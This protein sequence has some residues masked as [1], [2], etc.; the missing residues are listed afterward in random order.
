MDKSAWPSATILIAST[1]VTDAKLVKNLLDDEFENV[2]YSADPDRASEDF[3]HRQPD[4]LLLAFESLEKTERYNLGLFRRSIKIHQKPHRTI[5]LCNRDEVLRAYELCRDEIFD[6][7]ILFWPTAYDARRL[8]MAVHHALRGLA[9]NKEGGATS[10]DFVTQVR[11]L[12]ELETILKQR[13][14]EG[15]EHIELAGRAIAQAEQNIAAS[16]SGFARRMTQGELSDMVEVRNAQHLEDAFNRLRQESIEA[17]LHAVAETFHPLKRWADDFRRASAPHLDSIRTLNTLAECVQPV[18]M[19]VDDDEFQHKTVNM[20]L[21]EEGYRLVYVA[22]GIEALNML[23]KV[24]PD[25]ILMDI[26]MP[27]MDGLEVMRRMKGVARFT[28]IPIIM[29]T[30]NSDQDVVTESLKAGAIDFMV[31]PLGRDALIT[32]IAKIL[33]TKVTP[34]SGPTSELSQ[35]DL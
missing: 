24:L 16:F 34:S 27:D 20:L 2:F 11:R 1:N 10:T 28:N 25:L 17:P 8:P 26:S 33:R 31:K 18:V 13:I 15:D 32:K 6:D 30:G 23:R 22:S 3:D 19:M 29:I 7:Y 14:T 5:I 35:S 21:K 9:L 4:V 12:A